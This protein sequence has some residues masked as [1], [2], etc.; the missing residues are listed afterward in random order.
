MSRDYRLF[1][2]ADWEWDKGSPRAT[3]YFVEDATFFWSYRNGEFPRQPWAW[4]HFVALQQ[5]IDGTALIPSADLLRSMFAVRDRGRGDWAEVFM[6]MSNAGY[7][8]VLR[9][10]ID[11][12]ARV[13]GD[14]RKASPVDFVP[15]ARYPRYYFADQIVSI[16]NR[17]E[18]VSKLTS[19]EWS[20]SVAFVSIPAFRPF[21]G[22]VV[23]ASGTDS[24]ALLNVTCQG[25]C[26]L[27][28]SITPH[29]YWKARVDGQE[30]PL[31]VTNVGYQG[32][33]LSSG[34]HRLELQY[35]NP[36]I[37]VGGIVS[38]LALA[39]VFLAGRKLV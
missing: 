6:A 23:S 11:E 30:V 5:D 24:S 12:S 16:A 31:H 26:Y 34:N 32:L 36:L 7:R 38:L 27:V 3:A 9:P 22:R 2:Q 28:I 20:R 10:F 35:R 8:A 33:E 4:G 13:N 18:F 14:L 29:K 21:P 17:D 25:H 19:A 39:A 37:A 1:H 15:T